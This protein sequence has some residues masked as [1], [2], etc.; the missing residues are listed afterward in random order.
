M[1]TTHP[2]RVGFDRNAADNETT[3][4]RLKRTLTPHYTKHMRVSALFLNEKTL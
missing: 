3:E 1:S 2:G 4:S